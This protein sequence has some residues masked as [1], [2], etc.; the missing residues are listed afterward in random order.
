MLYTKGRKDN[1]G[2]FSFGEEKK[3]IG[4]FRTEHQQRTK[5]KQD[6]TQDQTVAKNRQ[7][8][9]KKEVVGRYLCAYDS[10]GDVGP[11]GKME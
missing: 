7:T 5:T 2:N 10:L 6:R 8:V 1:E 9:K 3:S 4:V 11:E